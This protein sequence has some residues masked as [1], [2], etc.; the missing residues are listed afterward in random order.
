MLMNYILTILTTDFS[1]KKRQEN[2]FLLFFPFHSFLVR[3]QW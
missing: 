1:G 3:M 2:N